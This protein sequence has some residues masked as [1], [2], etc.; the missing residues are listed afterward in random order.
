VHITRAKLKKV[1]A[2]NCAAKL[3]SEYRARLR[4]M[5][6]DIATDSGTLHAP[7]T[8]EQSL[9][10]I[11]A[12]FGDYKRYSGIDRFRG[13][14]AEVGPGDNCGV[15]LLFLND[16]CDFVDLVD[17]FYSRRDGATQAAVYKLL[18]TKYPNIL[19]RI[20][21]AGDFSDEHEFQSLARHYGEHAAAETFFSKAAAYDFIVSRAVLEHV[22]DPAL[23]VTRMA[24][25]L[26][27]GGYL[28]HK[29]DLSDHRL[30]SDDF[31]ELKFLEVPTVLYRN[32]VKA[33]GRPNRVLLGTYRNALSAAGLDFN[34]LVT[35]LA[36]VGEIEPHLAY[37][38]I[39]VELRKR[40]LQY[41]DSVRSRFAA[42]FKNVTSAD[43]SV[44]GIFIVAI[45]THG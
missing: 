12:V 16:G 36:G 13:R 22:Y 1:Y 5:T 42:E 38:D 43:L 32:M 20:R 14:V 31:H 25:A 29:V 19:A 37:E 45:K 8:A 21:T 15:G 4:L 33:S 41:V 39:P 26:K 11:E 40:S 30:F 7:F 9:N 27:R 34:V 18:C 24:Q 6:G 17:R 2:L 23:A 10:Y 28:L 3:L 35:R 44:A